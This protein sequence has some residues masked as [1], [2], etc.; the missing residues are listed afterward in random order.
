MVKAQPHVTDADLLALTAGQG[1]RY[2]LI[3][4]ELRTR[5][6][7][8][9]RHGQVIDTI[10]GELYVFQKSHLLG[11]GVTAETGFYTRGDTYTV[12]APD[13]AFIRQAKVPAAGYWDSPCRCARF[14][15]PNNT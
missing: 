4:G 2:E 7:A 3:E 15:N 1:E 13:Y 9:G 11:V 14:S 12:R 10:S 8:G 5:P 6:A